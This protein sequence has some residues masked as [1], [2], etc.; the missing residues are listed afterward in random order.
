L[1]KIVIFFNEAKSPFYKAATKL[2]DKGLNVLKQA[3][4][5]YETTRYDPKTGQHK[6]ESSVDDLDH[7]FEDRLEVLLQRLKEYQSIEPRSKH[8]ANIKKQIAQIRRTI[9]KNLSNSSINNDESIQ[10]RT[11]NDESMET[12]SSISP[13][14]SSLNV[15]KNQSELADI[16]STS[17][18]NKSKLVETKTESDESSSSE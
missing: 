6:E 15:T 4:R 17:Q 8:V 3:R 2:R 5:V 1:L 9:T 16:H 10:Q 7:T 12:V 11:T 14:V 18:T 13:N